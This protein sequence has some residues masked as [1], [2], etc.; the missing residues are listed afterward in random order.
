[1]IK[2]NFLFA[3]LF[4]IA[5]VSCAQNSEMKVEFHHDIS[6]EKVDVIINDIYFTSFLYTD[7]LKKPVLFPIV[8]PSG[9]FVTRGFPLDPRPYERV[10]HPHH[11]GLWFNFGDVNGIDFWN[12][13]SLIKPEDAHRYGS[14]TINQ[15]I[16]FN[17]EDRSLK[18]LSLWIDYHGEPILQE[19]VVYIFGGEDNQLRTIERKTRLTAIKE[20]VFN[21]SKEGMLGL[22]VDRSFEAPEYK[23]IRR[24]DSNGQ[25]IEEPFEYNEGSNGAYRNAEGLTK[26]IH[27]WGKK[28]SW[29]ALRAEKED[30]VITIVM[31]DHR[32]NINYPAW[33][34]TRE[35]GLFSINN[36]GGTKMDK[37]SDQVHLQLNPGEKLSFKHLIVVGGD[38]SDAA[39]NQMKTDFNKQ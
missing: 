33:Y 34:H 21:E 14:I 22:R 13:S 27:T 23:P 9:K 12:N 38:L 18:F 25:P 32:G 31:I 39:I 1:M 5:P 8:T 4:F 26:E 28:S 20:V 6:N 16:T 19:E 7:T 37:S 36:F 10:D 17:E 24:L 3:I 11:Y 15:P 2:L 29:V 35:Y 30:E